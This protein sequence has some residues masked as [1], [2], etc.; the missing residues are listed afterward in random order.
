MNVDSMGTS[1]SAA[2][3]NNSKV[4]VAADDDD[5][6]GMFQG[7]VLCGVSISPDILNDILAYVPKHD[8]VKNCVL[9]CRLWKSVLDAQTIWKL[10]CVRENIPFPSRVVGLP[11]HFYRR[12]CFKNPFGRNLIKNP[13]GDDKLRHW[14]FKQSG[15]DG[16]TVETP[17][18][19]V[20]PLIEIPELRNVGSCFATSY[21]E[22]IKYQTVD[23]IA[24]GCLEETLDKMQ[25]KIMVSDWYAARFDCACRYQ[26]EVVLLDKDKQE[27]KSFCHGP[28]DEQQWV[29]KQWHKVEHSFQGYGPGLRY[30]FFQQLGHDLQFW[31]G[32]YGSKMTASTV[33]VLVD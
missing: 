10:K 17:P 26:L 7:L 21:A 28:I 24:E 9:V 12:L 22:C 1:Q 30:V 16:W 27:M 31:A 20:D 32:H 13:C 19:G 11:R 4:V 33:R 5:D 2:V 6:D 15:G 18:E 23:L 14:I 3:D 8:L 25:P 29:G